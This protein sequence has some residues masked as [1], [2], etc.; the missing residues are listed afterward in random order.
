MAQQKILG[1]QNYYSLTQLITLFQM[2]FNVDQNKNPDQTDLHN[3]L[4]DTGLGLIEFKSLRHIMTESLVF[5]CGVAEEMLEFGRA[6]HLT[7]CFCS[8]RC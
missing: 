1:N 4:F 7:K 5:C 6:T 2:S 8:K 3:V